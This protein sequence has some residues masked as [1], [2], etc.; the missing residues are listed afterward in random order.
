VGRLLV[1]GGGTV[2]TQ[3][4]AADLADELHLAV[5][6]FLVGDPAAPRFVGAGTFRHD[7]SHRMRLVEARAV[8]DMAVLRY[9]LGDSDGGDR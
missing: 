9:R 7:A 1:E 5:A 3:F 8:G 6:P 2:H 4:L